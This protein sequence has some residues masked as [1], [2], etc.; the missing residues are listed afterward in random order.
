[1]NKWTQQDWTDKVRQYYGRVSP[2][3]KKRK[4]R[5]YTTAVFSFL[6]ISLFALYAIRPTAQTI[7]FL[8]REIADKTELN[9][10]ME[11]K[12]TALIEAQATYES[13]RDSLYVID[14]ALPENPDAVD[15]AK[16]LHTMA[17]TSGASISA[18]Q[19]PSLPIIADETAPGAKQAEKK[20]VESF[21]V[22]MVVSGSYVSLEAFLDSLLNARRIISVDTI[23]F[24]QA[25]RRGLGED[26]LQLSLRIQSYYSRQ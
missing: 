4:N 1:M 17:D 23:S 15:L 21:S 11:D 14:E 19:I 20:P 18:M 12:I 7:I 22:S 9:K 8:Q 13:I 3:L 26:I 2:A 5:A 10:K 24:R 25:Q 6:A 16:M